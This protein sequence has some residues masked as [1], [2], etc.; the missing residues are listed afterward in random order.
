M[1]LIRERALFAVTAAVLVGS[2]SA[3]LLGGTPAEL[4]GIA[5]GS[6]AVLHVE[7]AGALFAVGLFVVVVLARAWSGELPTEVSGRGVQYTPAT[8]TEAIRDTVAEALEDLAA[9]QVE[10]R[11]RLESLEERR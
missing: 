10:L 8:T 3:S 4:P 2:A 1:R 6:A 11:Q 9:V 7:R 5:M